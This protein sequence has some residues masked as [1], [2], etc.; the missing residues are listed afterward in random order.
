ML[1]PKNILKMLV[2]IG[3]GIEVRFSKCDYVNFVYVTDH[4]VHLLL[5]LLHFCIYI[6]STV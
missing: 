3:G 2:S 4:G 5:I 1:F 6:N